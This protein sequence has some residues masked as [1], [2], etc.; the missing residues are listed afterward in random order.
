MKRGVHPLIAGLRRVGFA[1]GLRRFVRSLLQL[2]AYVLGGLA[3]T[4]AL[5][6]AGWIPDRLGLAAL[7]GSLCA[8]CL[9]LFEATRCRL[10]DAALVLDRRLESRER[11]TT[12]LEVLKLD[13]RDAMA[14]RVVDEALEWIP[15][16]PLRLFPY[17]LGRRLAVVVALS[18]LLVG[19]HY[20]PARSPSSAGSDL[21]VPPAAG[22]RMARDAEKLRRPESARRHPAVQDAASKLEN[23]GR[24][25][26]AGRGGRYQALGEI[27]SV[28]QQARRRYQRSHLPRST[29]HL[30]RA[31]ASLAAAPR[32][33]ELATALRAGDPDAITS[34]ID[35]L[36]QALASGGFEAAQLR[37][38]AEALAELSEALEEGGRHDMAQALARA[39]EAAR[40][41][42]AERLVRS[43]QAIRIRQ[44]LQRAGGMC[45]SQADYQRLERVLQSAEGLLGAAPYPSRLTGPDY[46]I[47][48][49]D[50]E[51]EPFAVSPERR[52]A[53][54]QA[55]SGLS[56]TREYGGDGHAPRLINDGNYRATRVQGRHG[57]GPVSY[58]EY[59]AA[60]G[61]A[62][63]NLARD[64]QPGAMVE[65]AED[66]L[67]RE[68]IPPGYREQVKRYF[69]KGSR[70]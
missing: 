40:Q 66:A 10:P 48:S 2:G 43:L 49:T 45:Q 68:D 16:K 36:E 20:L 58:V 24:Q 46:G 32:S 67:A 8:V 11:I 15:G 70:P 37:P 52:I 14:R 7:V 4:A 65:G 59:R 61:P 39:A 38:I 33:R 25:I 60:A 6:W 63:L 64:A 69:E 5:A 27:R 22:R 29:P 47:G 9:A 55:D 21:T 3:L 62:G 41:G 42:N 57:E 35:S 26:A 18:L 13:R 12:A 53:D 56:R 51:A 34:A 23:L 44:A 28:R 1:L 30:E 17:R 31:L 54:R 50:Q 19:V